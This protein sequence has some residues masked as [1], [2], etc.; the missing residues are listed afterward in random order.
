MVAKTCHEAKWHT[1][2]NALDKE[3]QIYDITYYK[4]RNQAN[5]CCELLE[6]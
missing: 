3:K 4:Q 2:T 1:N 6:K 5:T